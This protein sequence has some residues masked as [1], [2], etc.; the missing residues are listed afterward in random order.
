MYQPGDVVLVPFPFSDLETVKK[1]PVL[2]LHCADHH[3]DVACL[4]VTS[5]PQH[6]QSVPLHEESF[7]DGKLPKP[8]WVRY[9]KI[10]TLNE[11]IMVGRFGSLQK[12]VFEK[13][14]MRFC[15]HFGCWEG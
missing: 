10:Y 14:R 13:V 3:G 4:A 15:E 12:S 9:G 1:R 11:S 8:S 6:Q 7:I 2:V 5:S